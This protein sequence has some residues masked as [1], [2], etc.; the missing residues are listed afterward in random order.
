MLCLSALGDSAD[1]FHGRHGHGLHALQI[2]ELGEH[3]GLEVGYHP[4]GRCL[5]AVCSKKFI[6]IGTA[7][8]TIANTRATANCK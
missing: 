8:F 4:L 6:R 5:S 7:A 2:T 1:A 3:V